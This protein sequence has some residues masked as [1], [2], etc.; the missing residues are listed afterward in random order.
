MSRDSK[1]AICTWYDNGASY[2][3]ITEEINTFWAKEQNEYYNNITKDSPEI[4]SQTKYN[5]DVKT[6]G[7]PYTDFVENKKPH[8]NRI[9]MLS[10]YLNKKN[11][12][13]KEYEYDYVMWLDADAC[14]RVNNAYT[15][16][17]ESIVTKYSCKD[18]I[19]SADRNEFFP[20]FVVFFA[21]FIIV[22]T[23]TIF[24]IYYPFNKFYYF[25]VLTLFVVGMLILLIWGTVK[26]NND[27]CLNS[28]VIIMKNTEYSRKMIDYWMSTDCYV[29]RIRPWQ[30]QGCLR[31]SY[32]KNINKLRNHSV[33]LAYGVLQRFH[34]NP[35]QQSLV[36]HLPDKSKDKRIE[37]FNKFKSEWGIN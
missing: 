12:E 30:D 35:K 25:S 10:E 32:V 16:L 17:F 24:Y 5:F 3:E 27:W 1:V 26:Y 20:F 23:M 9:P 19:F 4:E 34:Y 18:I 33:I 29:N 7:K 2:G 37:L 11:D 36:I 15:D 21:F 22:L 14:F 13:T 6:S 28:G 31:Y 8:W